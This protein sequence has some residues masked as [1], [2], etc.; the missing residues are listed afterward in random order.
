MLTA[1]SLFSMIFGAMG[2]VPGSPGNNQPG[3]QLNSPF[4]LLQ[5]LLNP[6]NAQHGDA[7][8][9]QEA[10]DRVISQ[11]M[12]QNTGS[13]APPPAAEAAIRSL[14]TRKVEASMMG[15]DG[16]AECSICMD[17]VEIDDEVTVLPCNHWFHGACVT[18]WL[19][20]HDTCPHCRKGITQP[21]G[22]NQ[23]SQSEQPSQSHSRRS[24]HRRSS[25]INIPA[26]PVVEGSRR[27]PISVP[28]SPRDIRSARQH[29]FETNYDRRQNSRTSSHNEGRRPDTNRT[30]SRSSNG[31][32][33]G[34]GGW[35]RNHMPSFQ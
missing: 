2:N 25:S 18:A 33:T 3:G 10:L 11:L 35:F 28:E 12:E 24:S 17:N 14:P 20:E 31:S 30:S 7:V 21:P 1:D 26:S 6:G 19:K 15:N 13:T 22:D 27:N 34:V 29:Y 16:K 8:F 9:S 23:R 5:H 4:S 32:N